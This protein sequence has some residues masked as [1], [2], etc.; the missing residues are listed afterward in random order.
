MLF[1]ALGLLYCPSLPLLTTIFSSIVRSVSHNTIT[2]TYYSI[3]IPHLPF[4]IAS[5]LSTSHFCCRDG[6]LPLQGKHK[7]TSST[8]KHDKRDNSKV[9][10]QS[11]PTRVPRSRAAPTNKCPQTYSNFTLSHHS[12]NTATIQ[13]KPAS[14]QINNKSTQALRPSNNDQ[15]NLT[16]LLQCNAITPI[17]SNVT[18]AP[19]QFH[20]L[21]IA[22]MESLT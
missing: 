1:V 10:T 21:I 14:D 9:R 22:W 4:Q 18:V 12:A 15:V 5:L 2:D 16:S 17:L 13:M 6:S 7:R 20:C 11:S 19:S 3:F 8:S